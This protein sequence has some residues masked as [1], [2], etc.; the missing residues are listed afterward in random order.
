[1]AYY[2]GVVFEAFDRTGELRALCG[3]G[4]Y[5][6]LAESLGGESI[7]AVGF[8]MGDAVLC[9]LLE[10]KGKL[11]SFESSST[12]D[13]LVYA[14][15][16]SCPDETINSGTSSVLYIK[17][18]EIAQALRNANVSVSIVMDC[19]KK[20]KWVL[21]HANKNHIPYMLLL[22]EDE[23]ARGELTLKDLRAGGGQQSIVTY[24][25]IIEKVVHKMMILQ[26]RKIVL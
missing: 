11:P 20:M 21:Q 23:H 13:V 12:I 9:E 3:G 1:L 7:P 8:G 24:S 10:S 6:H 19:E 2:T 4:R 25:D 15:A 14:L 17:A 16:V 26:Q 5:D 22:A 18:T